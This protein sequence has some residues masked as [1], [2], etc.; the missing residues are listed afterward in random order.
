MTKK[1]SSRHEEVQR[2][3]L[4][5]QKDMEQRF[6]EFCRNSNLMPTDASSPWK[7]PAD[8][9]ETEDSVV[10]LLDVAGVRK[11]ELSLTLSD[12]RLTVRGRRQVPEGRKKHYHQLEM[13]YGEFERVLWI[14][15]SVDR[16][17][18][19]AEFDNGM[20]CITLPKVSHEKRQREITIEI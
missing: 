8:V 9:F 18:I 13:E 10:V 14:N 19:E 2:E 7:P 16:A 5:L 4:K 12:D 11:G 3:M 6:L 15:T 20:L 1:R 17:N